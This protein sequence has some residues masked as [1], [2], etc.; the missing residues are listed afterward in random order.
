[1]AKKVLI[2]DDD[3][4]VVNLVRKALSEDGFETHEAMD[5]ES[6]IARSKEI[7]PDLIVLDILMPRGIGYDVCKEIKSIPGL[8]NTY[9]LFLTSRTGK[10]SERTAMASGGDD[11][12]TKP[13]TPDEIKTRVKKALGLEK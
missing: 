1:M 10:M 9:V 7:K 2:V 11:Y 12:M 13:F 8:E 6:A 4:K 5:G 3:L